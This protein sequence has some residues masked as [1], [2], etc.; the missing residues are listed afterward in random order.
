MSILLLLPVGNQ[1][2][3]YVLSCPIREQWVFLLRWLN[4]QKIAICSRDDAQNPDNLRPCQLYCV[5]SDKGYEI[6]QVLPT[7]D[8][9]SAMPCP[10]FTATTAVLSWVEVP[11]QLIGEERE[12][13]FPS[14]D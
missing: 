9:Q 13:N 6:F 7:P 5:A 4:E 3:Q 12:I 11:G 10:N 8:W 2:P 1:T 14:K